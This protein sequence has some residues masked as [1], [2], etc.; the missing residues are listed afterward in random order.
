MQD[1]QKTANLLL[2]QL[3]YGQNAELARTRCLPCS[4]ILNTRSEST[5]DLR[6]RTA[7]REFGDSEHDAKL[8]N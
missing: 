5:R 1:H 7:S 8:R 6:W 2:W 4:I 3:S